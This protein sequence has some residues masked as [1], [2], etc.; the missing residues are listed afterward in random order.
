MRIYFEQSGNKGPALVLLHGW[1]LNHYVWTGITPQLSDAYRVV[2]FDLPGHGDSDM[3][4]GNDYGLKQVAE[5]VASSMAQESIVLGWSLGGLIAQQIA[6][7]RPALVKGL[8]LVASS[9]RFARGDDWPH[10]MDTGLLADF[11]AQLTQ[12]YQ[13]TV[14]RFL[15][16]QSMGSTHAREEIRTLREAFSKVREPNPAA[17]RGGLRL[18]QEC[19]LRTQINS[20][21]CPVLIINGEKDRLVIPQTGKLMAQIMPHARHVMIKGAGHAPFLSHR[22]TFIEL[23]E[24]FVNGG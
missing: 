2:A 3:P 24:R 8:I 22:D 23:V 13:A 6:L 20:I 9:A 5:A 15:A 12:D 4:A 16:L 1:G 17:L 11:A 18:L 14:Q 21:H 10:G 7:L 19:D